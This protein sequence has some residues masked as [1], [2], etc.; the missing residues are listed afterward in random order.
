V[1]SPSSNAQTGWRGT[2]VKGGGIGAA[3]TAAGLFVEGV[4]S[5]LNQSF[6]DCGCGN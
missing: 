6:G 5:Q 2:L 3:S 4:L 1:I